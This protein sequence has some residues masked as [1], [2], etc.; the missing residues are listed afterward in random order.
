M[1]TNNWLTSWGNT[2]AIAIWIWS[3]L[4][5]HCEL[6]HIPWWSC[7]AHEC[8]SSCPWIS[9]YFIKI[10][11]ILTQ[12]NLSPNPA[13]FSKWQNPDM[14]T[15]IYWPFLNKR[16]AMLTKCF[17]FHAKVKWP[18]VSTCHIKAPSIYWYKLNGLDNI[19]SRPGVCF[20]LCI[21]LQ[22]T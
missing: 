12:S 3:Q 18:Q 8:S 16:I 1:E 22:F 13:S 2:A 6:K 9:V 14:L 21:L 7:C 4:V 15:F 19:C 17:Q 10:M 5:Y 20:H 11:W